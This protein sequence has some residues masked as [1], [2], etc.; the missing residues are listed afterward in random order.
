MGTYNNFADSPLASIQT[1]GAEVTLT[2]QRTSDT[3]GLLTWNIPAPSNGCDSAN[4][5]Y[6]GIVLTV[7][8]KPANY[9]T[10]SPI[11]GTYYNGDPSV[12]P[13]LNTGDRLDTA[14]VLAAFYDNRTTTSLMLTDLQP[15]TAYYFSAYPVDLVARYYTAGVHAYSLPSGPDRPNNSLDLPAIQDIGLNYSSYQ[16]MQMDITP[17]T[18][19]NLQLG[20]R[21]FITMTIDGKRY[22]LFID[23]TK[24]QD[25]QDL[26]HTINQEFIRLTEPKFSAPNPPNTGQYYVDITNKTVS[27][28]NGSQVI[29][30]TCLFTVD[31]PSTPINGTYWYNP[32]TQ[33]LSIW[34]GSWVNV[35]FT[36]SIFDFTNPQCSQFWFNGTNVYE[37]E[38]VLWCQLPTYITDV[39]PLIG[40]TLDCNTFWY[41]TTT[42]ILSQ[43][44]TQTL[45]WDSVNA[46]YTDI[47]PNT[48]SSGDF[49]YNT[50][51]QQVS[52]YSGGKWN[53][54]NNI[55]YSEPDVNGNF[56]GTL[57]ANYYWYIP[58]QQKLFRRDPTNT[59]WIQL[60]VT[61]YFSDP[62]NRQ[63]CQLWWNSATDVLFIWDIVN[64]KW[65]NVSSFFQQTTDPS[66]PQDI[67]LNSAWFNPTT[68]MLTIINNPDCMPANYVYSL[69]NPMDVALNSIWFD[70]QTNVWKIWNG[71]GWQ[72][73]GVITDPTDPYILSVGDL[74]FNTAANQLNQWNG[75]NWVNLSYSTTS[76]DPPVGQLWFNTIDTNL[77]KWDG[78]N[79]NITMGIAAA[80]LILRSQHKCESCV[81][82]LSTSYY[83]DLN[84]GWAL[85]F[86]GDF[87]RFYTNVSGCNQR[88][89]LCFDSAVTPG[90]AVPATGTLNSSDFVFANLGSVIYFKPKRG[91]SKHASGPTYLQLGVGTDGAPDARRELHDIIRSS[92]GDP[93]VKTELTKKE[94]DIGINNALLQLRKYAGCSVRRGFFFLDVWPMQQSYLMQDECVGFNKIT[95]INGLYRIRA[96]FFGANG[97]S[98]DGLFAW[99]ALTQLYSLGTFDMLSFHQTSS[100]IKELQYLFADFLNWNFN[101][102]S[103]ELRIFKTWYGVERILIDS[104]VERTEQD[105]LTD[106]ETA[107][108]IQKYTLVE[109]KMMLAQ[110]RG[111][112]QVLPGPNGNTTL[113]VQDLISQGQ[114]EQA[115]L[116]EEL[117]DM[118]FQNPEEYGY[119]SSFHFG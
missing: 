72:A 31:D 108:W 104:T 13:D 87:I 9:T 2:F 36:A 75:T 93:S 4:Q 112:F 12:D 24:A 103:R 105:L 44:N 6:N 46:I 18:K 45:A 57:F 60:D 85:P 98:G 59:I 97:F 65:I 94:I 55:S 115:L 99:N 86:N 96:G 100:Y 30:E 70:P 29:S 21:Y 74:W 88:L 73:I 64:T 84:D 61:L 37:W 102:N 47:D 16:P 113:N 58:S 111:K 39:N 48:I 95:A 11:N 118:S 76:L 23:G 107:L 41:N 5:A 43:W 110:V 54:L 52:F 106:R 68:N 62:T 14:L 1:E 69:T 56:V 90:T 92:L 53:I 79:W 35:P 19:T 83:F 33:D 77:Y 3:T 28:W 34:E 109:C 42:N 25:Y 40:P 63:S 78:T 91:Q 66:L 71:S 17:H 38:K 32:T 116:I 22:T 26:M 7:D 89:E 49:W 27:L 81:N 8:S 20:R 82:S 114:Q 50:T 80:K 15:K 117:H 51:T 67:P 119:R 10:T 101:E